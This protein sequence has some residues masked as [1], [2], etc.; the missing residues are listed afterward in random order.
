MVEV[1]ELPLSLSQP[2]HLVTRAAPSPTAELFTQH[3]LA[4]GG[5]FRTV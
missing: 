5:C 1:P 4:P 3:L 2:W